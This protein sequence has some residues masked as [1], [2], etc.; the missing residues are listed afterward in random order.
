MKLQGIH[1]LLVTSV[2]PFGW[3]RPHGSFM[4]WP[5]FYMQ[6]DSGAKCTVFAPAHQG[7]SNHILDN[8][9]IYRFRYFIPPFE[10]LT[11]TAAPRKLNNPLYFFVA[12]CYILL[13][14]L[15]L[16]WVCYRERPD[17]LNVH[18]PFP[19]GLMAWPAS[20]LL[21]IPMVFYFHGAELLLARRFSFVKPIL[22][23]L[24]PMAMESATNSS[25]TKSLIKSL[26]DYPV[27]VIPQAPVILPLLEASESHSQSSNAYTQ[28][29]CIAP[30]IERKGVQYL[31]EALPSVKQKHP[32]Q[33]KLIGSGPLEHSLRTLCQ[34]LALEDIV[35]FMGN[36]NDS[37][38]REEYAKCDIFVLP[39]I[40]DEKGDTE[41]LGI[42]MLEAM[43]FKKPVIAGAVGGIVDVVI[44]DITGILVPEKDYQAIA[45]AIQKLIENP[46]QAQHMGQQGWN[47]IQD[48]FSWS[49]ILPLWEKFFLHAVK[50]DEKK[51]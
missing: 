15:Q 46:A 2:Y 11:H 50:T 35:D 48:C 36:I 39:S 40:V 34:D 14:S 4:H 24:I 23:W 27:T 37:E 30:F 7:T 51:K 6:K 12:A 42:V 16:F 33:L 1:I 10:D 47:H 17:I 38:L 32:I 43:A 31:L 41:G 45:E 9:K 20:K 26:G 29:L 44:P 28:L 18:W 21:G 25:Y 5:L 8:I 22:C 13:G 49:V 19:H 3:D